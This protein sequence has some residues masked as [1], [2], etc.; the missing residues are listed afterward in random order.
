MSKRILT[1]VKK[2]FQTRLNV[3]FIKTYNFAKDGKCNGLKVKKF[4][5]DVDLYIL[6]KGENNADAPYFA[7]AAACILSIYDNRPIMGVYY[8]NFA[9]MNV[10][11]TNEFLYFATFAHE[12]THILGFSDNLY[13]KYKHRDG[14]PIPLNQVVKSK[15]E[16][17]K[18][19]IFSLL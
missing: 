17:F 8:L 18:N 11:R 13:D 3:T 10:S 7:A 9:K 6:V 1:N 14:T 5:K 12:F 16:N 15:S 19:R 2:F 4:K